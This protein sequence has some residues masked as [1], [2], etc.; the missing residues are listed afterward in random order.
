MIVSFFVHWIIRFLLFFISKIDWQSL[1]SVPSKGPMILVS[2]HVNFLDAPIGF[3]YLYPRPL[4]SLVKTE[5]FESPLFRFLFNTWGSIPVNRG[6]ADFEALGKCIDSLKQEKLL[7]IAPEGTRTNDGK[8]IQAHT[9]IVIIA[10]KSKS[11]IL[12]IAQVGAE[13]F[14]PNFKRLKRTHI[15]IKVGQPFLI[16]TSNSYPSKEERQKIADEIMYQLAK[17]MPEEYRGY[18]S[19]FDK[20]TTDYLDF[21]VPAMVSHQ[22]LGQKIANTFRKYFPAA[23]NPT[24]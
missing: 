16:K 15:S 6:T 5:T 23:K 24:V 19:D 21:N 7:V 2:N 11:P 14:H 18:Y 4:I 13:K 3:T 12:P 10:I 8:L 17:L 22:T 1:R 9:G 20:A